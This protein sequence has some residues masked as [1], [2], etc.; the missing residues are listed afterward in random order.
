MPLEY[1]SEA[2]SAGQDHGD[3]L[4]A[5]AIDPVEVRRYLERVLGSAAFRQSKRYAGVLRFMVE[6]RLEGGEAHLL[7]ERVIGVEIFGRAPDYDT[8]ADHVV[9]SAAAE[10]RKRLAQY[11]QEEGAEDA[12]RIEVQRGSYVPHFRMVEG[13]ESIP[14]GI[15]EKDDGAAE[16]AVSRGRSVR[17]WIG[18]KTLLL[19]VVAVLAGVLIFRVAGH[20]NSA[21]NRFWNPLLASN[22]A[23]LLCVGTLGG[24]RQVG[25][26]PSPDPQMT[27]SEFHA[28]DYEIVHLDDAETLARIA[29]LM[30]ARGKQ[31]QIESQSQATYADLQSEPVVLIGLEN[32]DWTQRLVQDLRFSVV[33]TSPYVLT[34]RDRSHPTD[35]KWSVNF[36]SPYLSLTKDYAIVDRSMDPKTGQMV[37]TIAGLTVFGTMA[38]GRFVTDPEEIRA[39]DAIAPRG[40]EHRN[41]ELVLSVDVI[42]G[43]PGRPVIIASR[44]W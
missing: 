2:E 40:W 37:V 43:V 42:R 36:A 31:Y 11:Y 34:I 17:P 3:A 32:N 18:W 12:L 10:V 1:L 21:I 13:L 27:L 19:A 24:G 14:L 30:Q 15:G 23:P 38:A 22:K 33:R 41:L 16:K 25:I 8:S 7:K 44:F 35:E 9:R 39:M 26:P 4:H 5:R 20:S 6:R 28:D 29:G